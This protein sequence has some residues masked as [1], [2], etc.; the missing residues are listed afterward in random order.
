MMVGYALRLTHPTL[1][2]TQHL[3]HVDDDAGGVAGGGGDEDVL[4]QPAVFC[5]TRLEFRDGAEIDQLWIDRLAALEF[6]Q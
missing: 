5:G 1:E 2:L 4:H 6:L 3:M